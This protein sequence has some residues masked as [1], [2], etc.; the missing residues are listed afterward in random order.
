MNQSMP[1]LG[2]E[3]ELPKHI[4]IIMDGN[5][6]WAN[7]RNLPRYEGH[8]HGVERVR[9]IIRAASELGIQYLTLYAFSKENWSRPKDE[10][11]FLMKLLG[12]YLDSELKEIQKSNIRF[13]MIGKLQEL[14]VEIQKRIK[15]NIETSEANTGL[16]LSLALSYSSRAE[17]LDMV[18][19]LAEE[20]KA[21]RLSPQEI[22]EK[23]ISDSLYTRGIPDPDLLIRTS[24]EL[25]ISNFLLWQISYTELYITDKNWPDFRKDDLLQAIDAYKLR[26]RRFGS[27]TDL[28]TKV[29]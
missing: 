19:K 14:P 25:R 18:R 5:G 27:A 6:R 13:R 12:A 16:T 3:N 9:E 8:R 22:D 29:G 26:D 4:A 17:I 7:E 2:N 1:Q 21:G 23:L 11:N 24:G 15:R 28:I 20:S 10:V